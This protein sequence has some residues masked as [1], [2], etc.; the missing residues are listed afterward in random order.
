[1]RALEIAKALG[2]PERQGQ[3]WRCLCPLHQGH[4]LTLRDGETGLLVTC[5]AGCD[6]TDILRE[7]RRLSLLDNREYQPRP[8]LRL[9]SQNSAPRDLATHPKVR[10][11]RAI[12]HS[13]QPA[14]NSPL[15]RYFDSRCLPW[16]PPASIRFIRDF[17][18]S[19]DAT[20]MLPAMIVAVQSPAGMISAIEVTA[21]TLDCSRKAFAASRR[22][23]GEMAVGAVRLAA[24][25][26]VLGIA[27]GIETALS[28]M[29]LTGIPVWACLGAQRMHRVAVPDQVAELHIFADDDE[30]GRSAAEKTCAAHLHIKR[31]TRLPPAGFIDWNDIVMQRKVAA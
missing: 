12:W 9:A 6:R 16:P 4:S 18:W 17:P 27:E 10:K 2:R 29:H 31:I 25:S 8:N 1:M 20:L 19:K 3:N 7:L 22:K 15:L 26:Q 13:A 24:A 5:W 28:A 21:L 14:E 11:A 23:E 30:A